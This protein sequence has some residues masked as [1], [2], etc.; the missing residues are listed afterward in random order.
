MITFQEELKKTSIFIVIDIL[1]V[2]LFTWS[3]FKI[4]RRKYAMTESIYFTIA[5]QTFFFVY[6]LNKKRKS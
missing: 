4:T 6:Y 5:M 1:M 3:W 2:F